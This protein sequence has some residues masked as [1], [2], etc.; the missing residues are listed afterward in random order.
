MKAAKYT[1]RP[2]TV[3]AVQFTISN[4]DQLVEWIRESKWQATYWEQ[5]QH[6]TL[7]RGYRSLV[8]ENDDWLVKVEESWQVLGPGEFEAEYERLA[9]GEGQKTEP[10]L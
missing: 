10:T 5:A 8:V 6:V 4:A 7:E 1:R 3:E 2:Q 9:D